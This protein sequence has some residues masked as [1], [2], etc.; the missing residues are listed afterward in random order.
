MS[1]FFSDKLHSQKNIPFSIPFSQFSI[2]FSFV[3]R[4]SL[5]LVLLL[6]LRQTSEPWHQTFCQQEQTLPAWLKPC[7]KFSPGSYQKNKVSKLFWWL[8]SMA[9]NKMLTFLALTRYEACFGRQRLPCWQKVHYDP[10]LSEKNVIRKRNL[11]I[12]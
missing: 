9:L 2:P 5:I 3:L 7:C 6:L 12:H 8:F 10:T 4:P 11:H 1:S